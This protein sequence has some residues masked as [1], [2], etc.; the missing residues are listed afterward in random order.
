MW[1]KGDGGA[2]PADVTWQINRAIYL[3]NNSFNGPECVLH[4]QAVDEA[5]IGS[6]NPKGNSTSQRPPKYH[7]LQAKTHIHMQYFSCL[8]RDGRDLARLYTL[9]EQDGDGPTSVNA[10][11]RLQA[12]TSQVCH[13]ADQF[14][15]ICRGNK[16]ILQNYE[17]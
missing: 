10:K 14:E 11:A 2:P 5:W 12:L 15:A 9:S 7:N 6:C 8:S 4:N 1:A 3:A 13:Q 16:G 17:Q